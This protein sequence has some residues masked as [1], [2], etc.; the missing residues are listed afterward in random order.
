MINI[1]ELKP[2]IIAALMPLKPDKIILNVAL[3]TMT[4]KLS[5][6]KMRRYL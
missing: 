2:Q 1:E 5:L 6:E 3:F 4:A